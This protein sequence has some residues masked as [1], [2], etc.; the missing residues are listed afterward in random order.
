MS[1]LPVPQGSL[2]AYL[3]EIGKF[4]ILKPEEEYDLAVRYRETG[5]I[6]AAHKLVT[7]NLRFVVKIAY[8][9]SSYSGVRMADLIQEGNIGLMTAVKKFDPYKGYRLISYAV[10]WI[11]AMIQ[12]FILKSWSLV[13]IGTT[14]AQRK[15]FYK[16]G[17]TKR[18]LA[19]FLPDAAFANRE[20]CDTLAKSLNVRNDD[21]TL[22]ERRMSARDISLDQ[23]AVY[24]LPSRDNQ[25]ELLA[26]TEERQRLRAQVARALTTL[27]G[28]ERFIVE[29]RLMADDPLTLREIGLRYR[30]SRE[31]ARQ[32]EQRAKQKIQKALAATV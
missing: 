29:K 23:P 20:A 12:N 6:E 11:R 25:E 26:R 9:Y 8:E 22:M 15:L 24:N 2:S 3:V 28:K 16:L 18:A 27:N 17:Q 21:I 10:W 30:I 14:Q 4:P 7:S 31:R 5:D 13:K 32:L 19:R 1:E